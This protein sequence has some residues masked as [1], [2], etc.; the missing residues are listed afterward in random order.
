[1][2]QNYTER[3]AADIAKRAL[4][5]HRLPVI[6]TKLPL[7]KG[8]LV[9]EVQTCFKNILLSSVKNLKT[10]AKRRTA[11]YKRLSD[12]ERAVVEPL[13]PKFIDRLK[14]EKMDDTNSSRI[15]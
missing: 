10:F 4:A 5:E 3:R 8:W 1:M 15:A 13:L 9:V 6:L 7:F 14:T 11:D 2:R 12:E